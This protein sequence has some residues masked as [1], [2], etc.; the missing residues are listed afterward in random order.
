MPMPENRELW[1]SRIG[2]VLS[3]LGAAIGLGS[4]WKFPYEVG[5][6]GGGVFI[7]FY[8]LALGLVV[9]PLML[10]EFA[11]GRRGR[12]DAVG[13]VRAVAAESQ[14][15]QFWQ[16]IGV[17]GI[18]TSYLVLSFYSVIG[19]W[20]FNYVA[21]TVLLGL[22]GA[23]GSEAQARF[24]AMLASPWSMAGY[25][26]L[27]MTITALIVGR[28]IANGI[29][30]A[31]KILMPLLIVLIIVLA[32][33]SVSH[34][35]LH[36]TVHFLF[37]IDPTSVGPKVALEAL[38]L[39][40]F[41]I[42]VGFAIMIT[43]G[44][45]AE[46]G[47]DLRQVA[48]VTLLGDTAVSFLA[49]FAVF[50]VVFAEKL[51]PAGGPGLIFVTLPLAFSKLPFGT[52]AAVMFFVLVAVAAIASAI[53]MLELPVSFLEQRLAFSRGS[54]TVVS[55]FSCGLIGLVSV[56]SFNVW[57]NWYPLASIGL[58]NVTV[59]DLLDQLTSNILLPIGSFAIAIFGGWIISSRL[60][61]DELR[62]SALGGALTR[63]LL[64]YI[65]PLAIVIASVAA[66]RF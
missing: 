25:H 39:S 46:S 41:S 24:D 61:A 53:S 9:F 60:L 51:D 57:A 18:V 55:A 47:I 30:S 52:F 35:D 5:T 21:E 14:A 32:V 58:T 66:V 11:V 63:V 4:I 19:G 29:E 7:F 27:F 36:S 10:V 17:I 49:G 20:S 13:S 42:G 31:C 33:Y 1:S 59:F 8:L 15:S 2:F 44:G 12:S 16:V 22:P 65:V 64:R 56:L 54:A 40:F 6:N 62:L 3:N 45:H 38:G 48:I 37:G 26:A 43:Y 28:G 23:T 50:P 34:G